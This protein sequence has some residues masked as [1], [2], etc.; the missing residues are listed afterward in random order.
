[1]IIDKIIEK[2]KN[3]TLTV[4]LS[5][6]LAFGA[7][8]QRVLTLN[9]AL[10]SGLKNNFDIRI[11][12]DQAQ[13][14]KNNNNIGT[15]G[16][17]PN[18]E[19]DGAVSKSVQNINQHYATGTEQIRNN[20]HTSTYAAGAELDW[21]IFN[22]FLMFG[23]KEQLAALNKAGMLNYR[24]QVEL[25]SAS[26]ISVYYDIVRQQQLIKVLKESI[27]ISV[28]KRDVAK[29]KFDIGSTAKMDYL[30][31]K[32]D[33]NADTTNLLIQMAT[34]KKA[35]ENLKYLIGIK[36]TAGFAVADTIMLSPTNN[37]ITLQSQALEQNN[38]I[39]ASDAQK[40]ASKAVIKEAKSYLYPTVALNS[41]YNFT[42]TQAEAGFILV[43]QAAGLN[44]G[45]TAR[46]NIFEG[47]TIRTGIANAKI[48]ADIVEL[49][50]QQTVQNVNTQLATAY[51]DYVTNNNLVTVV[52]D[53]LKYAVENLDIASERYKIGKSNLID[54]RTAQ[55][56]YVNAYTNLFSAIYN[57][58]NSEIQLMRL[59]GQISKEAQ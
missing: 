32:V 1:M 49:G 25:S 16:F 20:A 21:T 23:N 31:A 42:N 54:Y 8:A 35:K 4:V 12:R 15:A 58:K 55:L 38:Q 29:T 44:Y 48:N 52:K 41:R 7:D 59:S 14:S 22:G 6:L 11:S 18:L 2:M 53:N 34:L 50:Y 26:I 33:L 30:Q 10:Q 5:V 45:A 3:I 47:G 57:A 40:D 56:S 36:D 24:N 17:L 13:I 9:E 28:L 37:L 51:D 27:K 39:L 43:N 19:V 46:W